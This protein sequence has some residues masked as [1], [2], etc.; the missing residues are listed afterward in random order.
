MYSYF[1]AQS[2]VAVLQQHE[3]LAH[4][5]GKCLFVGETKL[6]LFVQVVWMPYQSEAMEL[7]LYLLFRQLFMLFESQSLSVCPVFDTVEQELA[8]LVG[9]PELKEQI[10]IRFL[11]PNLKPILFDLVVYKS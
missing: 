10:N 4:H 1:F 7:F 9:E 2:I 6:K 3:Y 8:V 11:F 5:A